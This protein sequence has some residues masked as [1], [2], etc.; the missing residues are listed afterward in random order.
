MRGD[1]DVDQ[2]PAP[3]LH[4]DEDLEH[5]EGRGHC[6]ATVTGQNG[7]GM[8]ADKGGPRLPWCST[9]FPAAP[10]RQIAANG[11]RGDANPEL[12]EEFRGNPLLTLRRSAPR[13]RGDQTL[14]IRRESGGRRYH[15][16]RGAGR[17]IVSASRQAKQWASRTNTSRIGSEARRGFIWR[18]RYNANCAWRADEVFAEGT[19]W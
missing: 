7:L 14:A 11:A 1:V 10:A 4:H 12:D 2:S 17:T 15:R 5:P 19:F 9:P 13:H 8:I 18:S 3:D 6:H 16:R